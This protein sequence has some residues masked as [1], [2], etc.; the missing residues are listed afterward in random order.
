[1]ISLNDAQLKTVMTA[2]SLVP[3]SA[4][5]FCS[6][7]AVLALRGRGHFYQ[8]RRRRRCAVGTGRNGSRKCG[9]IRNSPDDL[10]GDP[11]VS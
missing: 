2:A 1:M 8:Q 3:R 6:A 7:S 5:N 9:V 4:R 10:G 11:I